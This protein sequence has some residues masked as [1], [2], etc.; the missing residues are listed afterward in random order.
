MKILSIGNSF[1]Q[2]AQ[3]YLYKI[4]KGEGDNFK[5]INLV[6]GGCSLRTH[7]L[8]MLENSAKYSLEF[9]GEMTGVLVSMKQVLISDEWDVITLQ[10]ASNL[11]AKH[12]TY[13]PYIERLAEYVKKYCPHSKIYMHQTWAYEDGSE[14]LKDLAGYQSAEEMFKDIES[15]YKKACK[16]I[17][18]DG[19]I[20]CGQAMINA[21][22]MGIEKVHRDT[23]HASLGVGRYL[24]A[25]TWYKA[26]TGKDITN[27]N[28]NE[29]ELPV[30]E[31]E[32]KIVIKAVNSALNN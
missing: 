7:Y 3:R 21:T 18:A 10:Q 19:I 22:K 14:R 1:S 13:I 5:T 17:K 8:N 28:F 31:E 2:D 12:Q 11:S 4:A 32:R 9:N 15:S 27:N 30:S 29:F 20:P 23:F 6:I 16:L 25:L 24:L 26:L